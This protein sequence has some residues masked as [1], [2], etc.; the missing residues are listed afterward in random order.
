[1]RCFEQEDQDKLDYWVRKCDDLESKLAKAKECIEW[2]C[3]NVTMD[4]L[5]CEKI[6]KHPTD[7]RARECLAELNGD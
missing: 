6:N 4:D 1:M 2:Y 7:K 5:H 3:A